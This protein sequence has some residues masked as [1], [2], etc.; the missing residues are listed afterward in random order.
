MPQEHNVGSMVVIV[1]IITGMI[2][3]MTMITDPL[4]GSSVN[5]ENWNDAE[6]T[7]MAPAQ[8]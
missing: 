5:I 6:N 1:M 3:P 2:I 8:G 7:S 4:R